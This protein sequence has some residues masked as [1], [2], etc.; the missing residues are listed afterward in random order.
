MN[1]FGLVIIGFL[2]W[3]T[4][5]ATLLV[6]PATPARAQAQA[7]S[8]FAVIGAIETQEVARRLSLTSERVYGCLQFSDGTPMEARL[9]VHP[10]GMVDAVVSPVVPT[11]SRCL[12][13]T[14][15]SLPLPTPPPGTQAVVKVSF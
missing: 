4:T 8:L 10:G 3:A 6:V 1:R 5:L 7:P 12:E 9:T 15:E 13:H 2:G 14:L 11:A